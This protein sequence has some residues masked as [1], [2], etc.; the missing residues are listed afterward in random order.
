MIK[1]NFFEANGKDLA[2]VTFSLS[3]TIWADQICLVGDFNGW[4]RISHP[5]RRGQDGTWTISIN[6]ET[7]RSYKFY[8]LS[9][10]TDRMF[11]A[12][13]GELYPLLAPAI[14]PVAVA[15]SMTV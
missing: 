9:D 7:G 15:E 5:F 1:K 2:R 11:E 4:D 8:Y 12:Q 3:S 10:G 6:L 14:S 13:A